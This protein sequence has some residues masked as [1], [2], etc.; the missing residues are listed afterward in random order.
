MKARLTLGS[1]MLAAAL[2][3][4]APAAGLAEQHEEVANPDVKCLKCHT[5]NLKKKLEDGE[6]MSLRVEVGEF[7]G[8]A[9][10]VIGCTGCHRDIG[11]AKHP[12]REPIASARA[13]S[14]AQNENC[15]HC[16]EAR[17]TD[18]EDSIH[19]SLA[20]EGDAGAPLCSDCHNAHAVQ[21]MAAYEP[22]TGEP[23]KTC[24]ESIYEA[25]SQS[26]HGLAVT[27][28]NV[29]RESHVQAPICADCHQAHSVSAV[30]ASDHLKNTCLECHEGASLAH[31]QWLP[32]AG[33][34]L[35]SISC[36][37]CHSPMAERRVDLQL[38]DRLEQVP[39][40]RGDKHQSVREHVAAIDA[41]G[42][43]LDPVE[44]WKLVRRA[45]RD[46]DGADVVLRGRMEVT[47]GVDAH[48]IAPR[49]SAVRS[50]ENC[51]E[52]NA[53]AFQNV[54]VSISKPDGRKQRVSAE[55][56]VLS[57]PISVDSVGGFYAPGGTRIKLLDGVLALAIFGALA[58]PVGH[59]AL[60][61]IIRKKEKDQ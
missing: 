36:P 13:Y 38:Y 40:G 57:S 56:K 61:K 60:G 29:I 15:R 58:I 8:S 28:G 37:A 24:H 17:F 52:G 54:T 10:S 5:K 16:H 14:Q 4:A 21:S 39:M 23:C 33:M 3:A 19:A 46:G 2:L 6:R 9:H 42:D 35:D 27:N 48:R 18:Y 41:E 50:C 49:G 30:A 31:E 44:L 47:S 22:V 7:E 59:I 53:K 55:S 12:S 43:G 32:N 1:L 45:S 20:H 51:H 34:H 26:V 11:K 25:Y